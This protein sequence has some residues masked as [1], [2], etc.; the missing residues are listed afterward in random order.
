[1]SC[2]CNDGKKGG[3]LPI[4]RRPAGFGPAPYPVDPS[5]APVRRPRSAASPKTGPQPTATRAA[6]VPATREGVGADRRN[7]T[8]DTP[9]PNWG[10]VSPLRFGHF[11]MT[12][13]S[14]RV[15][16][17]DTLDS[18]GD[19]RPQWWAGPKVSRRT[20]PALDSR[21]YNLNG[22]KE[23]DYLVLAKARA[24]AAKAKR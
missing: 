7:R 16:P 11:V 24:A 9:R 17:L 8:W 23:K 21:S 10:S 3:G 1:M 14:S 15:Q 19:L 20:Y 12:P 4:R 6:Q 13:T 22:I 2:D 18:R 5:L